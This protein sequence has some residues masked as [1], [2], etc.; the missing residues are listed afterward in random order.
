MTQAELK[1]IED[2]AVRA[3]I[4]LQQQAGIDVVTDGELRRYAFYGH[5]IDAFDVF[6]R[7]GGWAI[8]FRDEK[9]E[10]LILKRPV[11]VN[12][13]RAQHRHLARLAGDGPQKRPLL[14]AHAR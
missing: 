2:A 12:R 5:L 4:E 11:V 6:D 13:L 3:A 1:Q 14:A 8:P 7:E 9:G 10:E